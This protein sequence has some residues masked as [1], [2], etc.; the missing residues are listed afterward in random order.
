ML[1][2]GSILKV[3]PQSYPEAGAS[4]RLRNG[5]VAFVEVLIPHRARKARRQQGLTS[6][7]QCF[8]DRMCGM[9]D[10]VP[11]FALDR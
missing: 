3:I 10:L 6:W 8:L 11:R 9:D 7:T 5:N 2:I 4:V 1:T